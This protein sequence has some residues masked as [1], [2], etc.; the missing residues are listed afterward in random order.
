[1]FGIRAVAV[2]TFVL[3]FCVGARAA[4]VP[5]LPFPDVVTSPSY[6]EEYTSG[7]YLR[8]DAGFRWNRVDS[9]TSVTPV[10]NSRIDDSFA[11]G[12][13]FGYKASWFRADLTIDYGLRMLYHADGTPNV[14]VKVQPTLMFGN[15]YLDLGTWFGFTPYVGA[16]VGAAYLRMYDYAL[17]GVAVPTVQPTHN[18]NFAWAYMAGLS[19]TVSPRFLIDVGYRRVMMGDAHVK[20]DPLILKDISAHEV[21]AGL[22]WLLD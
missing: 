19:Y 22:R 11:F 20:G 9:V 16:G 14:S 15:A 1:M 12:G 5:S 7:W 4:D 17:S 8:G 21:R 10:S 6:V 18:W 3:W 2:A 13:G